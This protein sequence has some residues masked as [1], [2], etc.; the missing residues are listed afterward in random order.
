MAHLTPNVHTYIVTICSKPKHSYYHTLSIQ[1]KCIYPKKF[2]AWVICSKG[3]AQIF[4][5]YG[6][7]SYMHV[8]IM[9]LVSSK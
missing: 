2:G 3:S 1:I 4:L 6:N 7:I 5:E 8:Y 9:F